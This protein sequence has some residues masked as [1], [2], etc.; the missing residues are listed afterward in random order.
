MLA[1][2]RYS[3][4]RD[5]TAI[6]MVDLRSSILKPERR[7]MPVGWWTRRELG[8]FGRRRG[9]VDLWPKYRPKEMR[10]SGFRG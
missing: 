7:D 10:F 8:G 3:T 6:R 2:I 1:D 5:V 9:F 4:C